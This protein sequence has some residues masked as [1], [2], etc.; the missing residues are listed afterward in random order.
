MQ[1]GGRKHEEISKKE[2]IMKTAGEEENK[3]VKMLLEFLNVC[4]LDKASY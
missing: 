2:F 3:L 4:E 1:W